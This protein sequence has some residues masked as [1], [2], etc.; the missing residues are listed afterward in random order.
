[1][2]CDLKPDSTL[3]FDFVAKT[4]SS[5]TVFVEND[6]G[7]AV[8]ESADFNGANVPVSDSGAITILEAAGVNILTITI[9]GAQ[10]DDAIRF[11]E[12]CGG[13]QTNLLK[14]F[15]FNGDPVRRYQ[16]HAS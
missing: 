6:A 15:I 3:A 8:I 1:M 14:T 12:D 2:T 9:N 16:I 7:T 11:K 10:N 5:S 4:G 13:N